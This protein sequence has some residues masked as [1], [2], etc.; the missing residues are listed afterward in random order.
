MKKYLIILLFPALL[1]STRNTYSNS[2]EYAT[3]Q[4]A[5]FIR[6]FSRNACTDS[7]DAANYNPAGTAF[8]ADGLW[9]QINSQTAFKN[10]SQKV[11]STGKEYTDNEPM[12]FVP[13]IFGVYKKGQFAGFLYSTVLAGGGAADFRNGI[14]SQTKLG[15]LLPPD[16]VVDSRAIVTLAHLGYALGGAYRIN[17]MLSIALAGRFVYAL[18]LISLQNDIIFPDD[19][20]YGAFAGNRYPKDVEYNDTAKGFGGIISIDV[21]PAGNLNIGIRYET[22]TNLTFKADVSKDGS[23]PALAAA[24]GV[25]FLL[26]GPVLPLLGI[27]DGRKEKKNL[28][29]LFAFGADCWI[30]P[31]FKGS[32]GGNYYFIKQA[33][34]GKDG[35]DDDYENG[36]ETHTGIEYKVTSDLAAS[37][38]YSYNKRGGSE[39]TY[40]DTDMSLDI[41]SFGLG[42][43]YAVSE[44]L[45]VSLGSAYYFFVPG[46][47]EDKTVEYRGEVFVIALA[48][49]YRAL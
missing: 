18:K 6:I 35:Y 30:T 46:K 27:S 22:Q 40:T 5:D 28:P 4:S 10:D 31:E 8:L 41:H 49:Q 3:N 21:K 12:W 48:V 39:K 33:D 13:S 32:I 42:V 1:L 23:N 29:A 36:W 20:A 45:D 7:A 37:M 17:D 2:I 16:I 43:K 9:M 15:A 38:G 11:V 19:T 47:N 26:S 44:R 14:V 34:E 24:P 25:G